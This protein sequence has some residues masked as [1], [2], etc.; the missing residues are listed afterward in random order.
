MSPIII[1]FPSSQR[2]PA[3]NLQPK[4]LRRG[5]MMG[6]GNGTRGK[7]RAHVH[8][9]TQTERVQNLLGAGMGNIVEDG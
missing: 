2:G 4:S 9:R 8:C 6:A 5:D 3:E 1:M 7:Q